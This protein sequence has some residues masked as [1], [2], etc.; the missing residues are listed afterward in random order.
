M[1]LCGIRDEIANY[2]N[3]SMWNHSRK[4]TSTT[5]LSRICLYLFLLRGYTLSLNKIWAW[6]D[7]FR[8]CI[9]HNVSFRAYPTPQRLRNRMPPHP[10]QKEMRCPFL[11]SKTLF[12]TNFID[13][14]CAQSV[15]HLFTV[16]NVLKTS[17]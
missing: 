4:S 11:E 10:Y 14:F 15:G 5:Q 1:A 3:I 2:S 17:R 16:D 12:N 8:I 9:L 6:I 7:T 13:F